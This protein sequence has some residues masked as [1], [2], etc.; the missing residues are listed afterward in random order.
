MKF[1]KGDMVKWTSKS[2][3]HE[4]EKRGTVLEI[5]PEKEAPYL[6]F[7]KYKKCKWEWGGGRP[8]DH[9]SYL[10]LVGN[11]IYWPRVKHLEKDE[12]TWN[13]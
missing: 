10:V 4:Y 12:I 11:K 5:I 13:G 9:E 6:F 3:S 7:L 2:C 8:R 1:K